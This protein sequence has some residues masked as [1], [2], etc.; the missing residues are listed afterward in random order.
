MQKPSP[1][2]LYPNVLFKSLKVVFYPNFNPMVCEVELNLIY[3]NRM[4]S[5]MC[6]ASGENFILSFMGIYPSYTLEIW[7]DSMLENRK[8]FVDQR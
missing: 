6:S 8:A 4:P 5:K 3:M 2:R 1:I 7:I